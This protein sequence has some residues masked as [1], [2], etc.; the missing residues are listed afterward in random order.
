MSACEQTDECEVHPMWV[1][2]VLKLA[3][4]YNLSFGIWVV[5]FPQVSLRVCGYPERAQYPELWQCI[6]MIVGVY[7]IGYW[8]AASD[9]YRHWPIV[10]VGL[11]GKVFGPIG[12]LLSWWDGSLPISAARVILFNDLIWW[13]PFAVILWKSIRYH[14][15]AGTTSETE[16]SFTEAIRD[17]RDQHGVSLA[18]LSQTKRVLV[19]F[20]RHGGCTFCREAM[21]ELSSHRKEIEA[22]GI[23]IAIVHM[24]N[25]D[26]VEEFFSRY[27]L[28]DVSRI[29][30]PGQV[31]YRAFGIG[32]GRFRQLMNLKVIWRGFLTAII[33]GHG[34]SKVEGNALRMPG[35]FLLEDGQ[36]LKSFPY[37]DPSDRPN[38][39]DFA[40]QMP[41]SAGSVSSTR[42]ANSTTSGP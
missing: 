3:G 14:Q 28:E 13:V 20:L 5:L 24:E 16:L 8:I 38:Y 2:H 11:L 36:I 32:L 27:Q 21:D 33:R 42:A 19:L 4:V 25:V 17:F 37:E 12:F 29:S 18:E 31:L 26:R 22:E 15:V 35:T 30:D 41:V 23:S 9:A 1:S 6:G 7:G 34:F 39:V 10:F 40:C